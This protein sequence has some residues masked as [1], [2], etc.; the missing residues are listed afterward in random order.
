MVRVGEAYFILYSQCFYY[1]PAINLSLTELHSFIFELVF[2][3]YSVPNQNCFI[4]LLEGS[5]G[6]AFYDFI[7]SISLVELLNI[8]FPSLPIS[9]T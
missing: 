7:A 5:K 1:C 4:V 6:V 9:D 2:C 3:N 8:P